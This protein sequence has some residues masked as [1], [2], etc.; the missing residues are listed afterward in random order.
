MSYSSQIPKE[1]ILLLGVSELSSHEN[2][3]EKVFPFVQLWGIWNHDGADYDH[4]QHPH[5]GDIAKDDIKS[6]DIY[7]MG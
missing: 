6:I 5:K 3:T 1:E 2:Q 7:L 4:H